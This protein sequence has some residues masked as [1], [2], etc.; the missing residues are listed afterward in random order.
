[1]KNNKIEIRPEL[2]KFAEQ[3]EIILRENDY[4][5]GLDSEN[6]TYFN[7]KFNSHSKKLNYLITRYYDLSIP[8]VFRNN[9]TIS[10]LIRNEVIDCANY[11]LAIYLSKNLVE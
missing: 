10:N 1:M 3:M 2:Q 9:K 4:K 11:L 6:L 7:D 8:D 5:S